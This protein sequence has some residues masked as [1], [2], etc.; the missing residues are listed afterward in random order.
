MNKVKYEGIYP[1]EMDEIA[2]TADSERV[3][4]KKLINL[5][6]QLIQEDH[7]KRPYAKDLLSQ[8]EDQLFQEYLI[9]NH[10]EFSKMVGSLFKNRFKF[11]T[12]NPND[13]ILPIDSKLNTL[14][15]IHRL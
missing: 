14:Y 15:I 6:K 10:N 12:I 8:F 11:Q 5:V 9:Q 3:E 2:K 7:T 1:E 13:M 4:E